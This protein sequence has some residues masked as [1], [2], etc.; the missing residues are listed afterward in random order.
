MMTQ[1]PY[2]RRPGHAL[3]NLVEAGRDFVHGAAGARPGSRRRRTL[4]G[5]SQV[6]RWVGEGIHWLL[7]DDPEGM[8]QE[9]PTAREASWTKP[10]SLQGNHG[11]RRRPLQVIPHPAPPLLQQAEPSPERWADSPRQEGSGPRPSRPRPRSS[12]RIRP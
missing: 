8:A 1:D 4:G 12:R 10:Q 2:R 11:S 3:V 9:A 5:I 6:G 7:E